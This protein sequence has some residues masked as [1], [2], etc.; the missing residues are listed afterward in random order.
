VRHFVGRIGV[1]PR[2]A[3]GKTVR[4]AQ[5]GFRF[6]GFLW[7]LL[8]GT[9]SVAQTLPPPQVVRI[10]PVVHAGKLLIDADIDFVLNDGWHGAMQK[11]IPAYFTADL[12]IVAPRWWWF[13]KTLV[14][15]QKTWKVTY[16]ALTRQWRVGSHD[17]S[18]PEASLD[19]ALAPVRHI[20]GWVVAD[21]VDINRNTPLSGRLRLRLDTPLLAQPLQIEPFNSR[22][23]SWATPWK[24]FIF[25]VV[26]GPSDPS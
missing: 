11:G 3:L 24:Q 5:P 23:W 17:L 19:D 10:D 16:N 1:L 7:V 22:A 26:T 20:R 2:D 15:T 6:A 8:V 13:N 18:L 25:S 21:M 9:F 4:R 14:N 12:E